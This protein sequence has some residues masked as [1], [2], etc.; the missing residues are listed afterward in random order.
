MVPVRY[1]GYLDLTPP[2]VHQLCC[3]VDLLCGTCYT[4][5]AVAAVSDST[6]QC[7]H[8]NN[9]IIQIVEAARTL[10]ASVTVTREL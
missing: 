9:N 3:V 5:V 1:H 8:E 2:P 7:E 4:A 10:A 6:S